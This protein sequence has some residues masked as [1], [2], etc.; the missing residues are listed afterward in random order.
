ML[1][2]YMQ[3]IPILSVGVIFSVS[4]ELVLLLERKLNQNTTQ[5][6]LHLINQ[7]RKTETKTKPIK[8]NQ[9]SA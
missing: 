1:E 6:S 4:Y 7:I 9:H 3:F 5:K 2:N 8:T